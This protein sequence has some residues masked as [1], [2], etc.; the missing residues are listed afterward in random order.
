M[1]RLKRV[2]CI[3]IAAMAAELTLGGS[4]AFADA[5]L[6]VE[7]ETRALVVRGVNPHSD[8]VVFS[9]HRQRI[10]F[11]NARTVMWR[12]TGT[13]SKGGEVRIPTP[14]DID[15]DR[16]WII[17]DQATGRYVITKTAQSAVVQRFAPGRIKKESDARG[18]VLVIPLQAAFLLV[19]HP[20]DDAWLTPIADGGPADDDDVANNGIRIRPE[21][22]DDFRGKGKK[23]DKFQK[24]DVAIA[25]ELGTMRV[26]EEQLQ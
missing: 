26:M 10:D 5:P 12:L 19:V 25:I 23:A 4:A 1:S 14:S 17:V 15:P 8:V 16:L 9:L 13:E 24:G 6:R 3:V 20:G 11:Q 21:K 2:L 18:D 7:F 22:L